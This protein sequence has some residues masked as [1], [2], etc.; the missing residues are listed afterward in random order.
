MIDVFD[1]LHH[2][3]SI[4]WA[5]LSAILRGW[6]V[7]GLGC[8]CFGF[9]FGRWRFWLW[10][11]LLFRHA[12][13]SLSLGSTLCLSESVSGMGG[14]GGKSVQLQQQQ[15]RMILLC[16]TMRQCSRRGT[17]VPSLVFLE[18]ILNRRCRPF[19]PVSCGLGHPATC[20]AQR[21]L[22]PGAQLGDR[23]ARG[24]E[25]VQSRIGRSDRADQRR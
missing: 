14:R 3:R 16:W 18:S 6:V 12:G 9:S 25:G 24:L 15:G 22:G 7:R 5:D 20:A 11:G 1:A 8:S 19:R 21:W 10:L 23:R 2:R 13:L 4:G 17:H